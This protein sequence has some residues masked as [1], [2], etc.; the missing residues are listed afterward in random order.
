ML[1]EPDFPSTPLLLLFYE[2]LVRELRKVDPYHL[3][4]VEGNKYA[5]DFRNFRLPADS[6]TICSFHYYPWFAENNKAKN[7]RNITADMGDAPIWCGEWGEDTPANLEEI[8]GLLT[9]LPN[10]C[11]NAFWTW[12]RVDENTG[13]M[14]L[15]SVKAPESWNRIMHWMSVPFGKPTKKE[16]EKG[17]MEFLEAMKFENCLIK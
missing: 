13:H 12:K 17:M 16:T 14:P 3:F 7:L 4:M 6:N 15:C 9:A 10:N 11:G 2:R 8:K 1:N 5:H